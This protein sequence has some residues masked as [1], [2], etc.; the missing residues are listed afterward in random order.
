MQVELAYRGSKE[1][2]QDLLRLYTK[3]RGDMQQVSVNNGMEATA[4]EGLCRAQC[5]FS[6]HQMLH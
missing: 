5:L 1:E 4:D 6:A 2:A 3:F